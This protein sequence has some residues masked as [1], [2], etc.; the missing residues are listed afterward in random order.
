MTLASGVALRPRRPER[1]CVAASTVDR[2]QAVLERVAAEDVGERGRDHRAEAP[3]DSAHGACSREEPQPKLSPASR[4]CAPCALG[5]LRTKS[6]FG[7]PSA[8]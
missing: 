4:I 3:A 8:S 6:G 7:E 5:W 1:A 2:Q